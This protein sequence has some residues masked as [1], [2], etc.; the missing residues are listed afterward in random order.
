[1]RVPAGALAFF[2][3]SRISIPLVLATYLMVLS[4]GAPLGLFLSKR[5]MFAWWLAL[6]AGA[7]F[8]VALYAA[9]SAH[10]YLLDPAAG[11]QAYGYAA[12][13]GVGAALLYWVAA[14]TRETDVG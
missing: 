14:P 3:P 9:I 4:V 10:Y 13:V 5:N 1:M 12:F 8:G 6:A 7:L 2:V 11:L